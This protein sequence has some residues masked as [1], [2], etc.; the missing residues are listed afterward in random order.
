MHVA[1]ITEGGS[2]GGHDR[3]YLVVILVR[4][5]R[6]LEVNITSWFVCWKEGSWTC[7]LSA[8]IRER[9]PLSRTTTESAF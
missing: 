1:R 2:A 5:D 8:A 9:A 4:T 6:A 7:N 3:R